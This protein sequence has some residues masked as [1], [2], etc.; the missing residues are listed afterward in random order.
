M[1]ATRA[2]EA[3][4]DVAGPGLSLHVAVVN[5]ENAFNLRLGFT[6]AKLQKID[7]GRDFGNEIQ[8][9]HASKNSVVTQ[10]NKQ[11]IKMNLRKEAST[12]ESADITDRNTKWS[13]VTSRLWFAHQA[14]GAVAAVENV[15]QAKVHFI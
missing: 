14:F 10:F 11:T 2:A 6:T 5:S 15:S 3:H 1:P 13:T 4:G 8:V 12:Y 7:P 9:L